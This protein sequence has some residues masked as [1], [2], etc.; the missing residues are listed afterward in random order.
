MV[1]RASQPYQTRVLPY[2]SVHLSFAITE[3]QSRLARALF[4]GR[5]VPL[6]DTGLLLVNGSIPLPSTIPLRSSLPL[7]AAIQ[8]AFN[9]RSFLLAACK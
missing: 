7:S 9:T 3:R 8:R 2:I 1:P 4:G 5:L 6:L